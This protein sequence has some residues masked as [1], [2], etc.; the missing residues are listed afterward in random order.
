MEN[1][2]MAQRRVFT[3]VLGLLSAFQLFGQTPQKPTPKVKPDS[4]SQSNRVYDIIVQYKP[5]ATQED[6]SRVRTKVGAKLKKEVNTTAMQDSGSPGLELISISCSAP[7]N[8]KDSED[9]GK[10]LQL[11]KALQLIKADP[12]VQ[13]A[14]VD[15]VYSTKP[16]S[17]P[18]GKCSGSTKSDSTDRR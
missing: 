17:P 12:A 18:I 10:N 11:T 15:A 13:F 16:Q 4:Q 5:E 9:R 14:E 8:A 2:F 3:L 6:K 7:D 1:A